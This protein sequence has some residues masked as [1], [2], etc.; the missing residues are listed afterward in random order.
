MQTAYI[1]TVLIIAVFTNLTVE[2][3]KKLLDEMGKTYKST[4]LAAISSVILAILVS[5]GTT[6]YRGDPFGAKVVIETIGLSYISFLCATVG[7]DKVIE[8]LTQLK[9]PTK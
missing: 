8:A 2:G 5:L 6:L 1:A 7:Y 9:T 4:V 3:L